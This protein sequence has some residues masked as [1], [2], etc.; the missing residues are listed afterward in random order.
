MGNVDASIQCMPRKLLC[1]VAASHNHDLPSSAI[2][3]A[4]RDDTSQRL[5]ILLAMLRLLSALSA[6]GATAGQKRQLREFKKRVTGYSCCGDVI[7]DELF[8]GL[9]SVV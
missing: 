3:T 7:W 1:Y 8:A 5:A 9:W 6:A 4:V 2:S